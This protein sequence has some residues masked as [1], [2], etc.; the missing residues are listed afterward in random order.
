M[1]SPYSTFVCIVSICFL[2]STRHVANANFASEL[3]SVDVDSPEMKEGK[4]GT[5]L[6]RLS[7]GKSIESCPI[8]DAAHGIDFSC[9]L[10]VL[11]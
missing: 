10:N 9:L 5:L 7:L 3:F 1:N 8:L 11:F 4:E 6:R 2:L